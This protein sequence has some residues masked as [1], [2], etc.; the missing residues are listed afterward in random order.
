MIDAIKAGYLCD[1]LGIRAYTKISLDNIVTSGED[2]DN[3]SLSQ[4]INNP[5]RNQQVV[6][7]WLD[8]G[9]GRKTIV[10]CAT[11]GH[12]NAIRD[13]FLECGVAAETISGQDSKEDRRVKLAR[14]KSRQTVVL[15]NC[16]V[17]TEG[18]NDKSIGCVLLARPTK[19]R[20]LY[21]QMVGRGLRADTQNKKQDCVLIDMHD[22]TKNHTLIGPATLVGLPNVDFRGKTLTQAAAAAEQFKPGHSV[23]G[24]TLDD[25]RYE[26]VDPLYDKTSTP[27]ARWSDFAWFHVDTQAYGL[28]VQ[29]NPPKERTASERWQQLYDYKHSRVR[30]ARCHILVRWT[31]SFW[32]ATF[33]NEDPEAKPW[34][35][36]P[37]GNRESIGEF[38]VLADAIKASD[39]YVLDKRLAG[40][41]SKAEI[42]RME[43]LTCIDRAWRKG[44]PPSWMVKS[45]TTRGISVSPTDTANDVF[46]AFYGAT[47]RSHYYGRAA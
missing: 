6:K 42:E 2:F 18:Y 12:A 30:K 35:V 17:L 40:R 21:I 8:N 34:K 37:L 20:L 10:F 31:G 32:R 22:N 46:A 39:K 26:Q 14:H 11:V 47:Y 4:T 3:E 7:A 41:F 29:V 5:E 9:Q 19:S 44:S 16:A 25:L 1:L 15:Y 23:I 13:E 36:V 43:T 33:Q 28:V 45:L 38:E 27:M 24:T